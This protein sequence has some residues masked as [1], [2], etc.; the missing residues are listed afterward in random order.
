MVRTGVLADPVSIGQTSIPSHFKSPLGFAPASEHNVG[1]QSTAA[2]GVCTS[3]TWSFP[4]QQARPGVRIPPSYTLLLNPRSGALVLPTCT[5]SY[6]PG[7]APP[8]L[9]DGPCAPLSPKKM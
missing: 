1:I 5:R 8:W 6:I 4:G 2:S 7:Y 9:S 3:P